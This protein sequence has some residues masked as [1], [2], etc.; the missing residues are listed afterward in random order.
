MTSE[1]QHHQQPKPNGVNKSP[2]MLF[3]LVLLYTAVAK[4]TAINETS[5]QHKNKNKCAL[6]N[7]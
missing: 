2:E 5:V 4:K 7:L 6:Y 3:E 1:K